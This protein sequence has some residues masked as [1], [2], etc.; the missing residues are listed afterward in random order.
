MRSEPDGWSAAGHH[1][2]AARRLARPRRSRPRR[3]RPPPARRPP[4]MARR[5]TCTIIGAPCDSASGLP[6]SRVGR[7]A[8][9]DE[10]DGVRHEAALGDCGTVP[11]GLDAWRQKV[12]IAP[13]LIRVAKAAA[14]QVIRLGSAA[15]RSG[16]EL[17]SVRRGGAGCMHGGAKGTMDSVAVQQDRRRVP[18]HAAVH[19]GADDRL[20]GAVLCRPAREARLR[21]ARRRRRA[22][23]ASRHGGCR[24]SRCRCCSPRPTPKKG[25]ADAKVCT[26]CHN[27]EK[28]AGAKVGPP[29]YGVVDAPKA[30]LRRASPIPTR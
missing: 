7:H 8:G 16:R 6:G 18:G 17:E 15:G 22:A 30:S 3:S 26:A 21:P 10:D 4:R 20:R 11:P 19:D 9:R 23:S 25:Q 27:F 12:A 28:G 13:R 14:K 1:R 24:P 2:L 5:Q 29:L